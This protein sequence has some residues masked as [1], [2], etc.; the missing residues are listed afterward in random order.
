V[1][2]PLI[3]QALNRMGLELHKR[4]PPAQPWVPPDPALLPDYH[5]YNPR[6]S[7]WQ[8]T[9]GDFHELCEQIRSYT[10]V[11]PDCCY[12]L[13]SLARQ[14]RHCAGE[15]WECG[16]YKGGTAMLLKQVLADCDQPRVLRLFDT[17]EGLPDADPGRD[18]HRRGQFADTSQAEVAARVGGREF[19]H[20]HAGRI[21]AT[22]AGL[23]DARIAFAHVDVDLYESVR[24]CCEFIYPRLSPGA[25]MIFDDYGRRFCPGARKA[26][27][28]YFEDKPEVVLVLGTGQGVVTALPI[29]RAGADVSP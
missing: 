5:L 3:K 22:F 12:V 4:R 25:V 17:F 29:S 10:L 13:R 24:D 21:P 1:I 6:Y 18:F 15:F 28:E 23:S 9:E 7:P 14:A 2:R 26:V 20:I 27:D 19:V 8:A 16:V 11:S